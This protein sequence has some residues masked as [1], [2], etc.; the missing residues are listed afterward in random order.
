MQPAPRNYELIPQNECKGHPNKGGNL[1]AIS[2]VLFAFVSEI[3]NH[4]G[5]LEV[6]P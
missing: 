2:R 6:S 5:N 4:S 3:H 1:E